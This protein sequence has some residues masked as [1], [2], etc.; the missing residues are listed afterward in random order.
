MRP[1]KKAAPHTLGSGL[2]HELA[3]LVLGIPTVIGESYE[4]MLKSNSEEE[5][6]VDDLASQLLIPK[7]VVT[8]AL[9][10]L[11]IV[12]LELR[13]LAKR[14]NVSEL[15][16]AVRVCKLASEIGLVNA[17]VV[18]FDKNDGLL[19]QYSPTLTM[20]NAEAFQLL[21]GARF[22]SP[23]AFRLGQNDDVIV[24]SILDNLHVGSTTMF[25]QL[26][27]NDIGSKLSPHETRAK[28][29]EQLFR[30]N[31]KLRQSMSGYMGALKTRIAGKTT[32]AVE[33][34]FWKRYRD[35]LK[36]TTLNSEVGRN[37][38]K[39]RIAEWF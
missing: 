31:D 39:A 6:Q 36:N 13:K 37:Y 16:T 18:F 11:P 15:A 35:K 12:A 7:N 9:R 25:V 14:A 1:S 27:P 32:A 8:D 21:N 22:A 19:W 34:D 20:T 24:A 28:V 26:L 30:D 4:E 5:R 17:S 2:A 3:H 10:T 23:E 29:E 33:A 38:V